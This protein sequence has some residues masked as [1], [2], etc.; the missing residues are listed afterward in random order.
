MAHGII[1]TQQLI[2]YLNEQLQPHRWKDYCPNGLQ[3]AGVPEIKHLVTAVSASQYVL[4]AA[5]KLRAQAILVHHGYFWK[6][7]DPCLIG[8]KRQRLATLLNH[9]INLIAYHL[10]LDGHPE[11]GNNVQL[12][13]LLHLRITGEFGYQHGPAIALIG[14]LPASMSGAE[15][16]KF[17]TVKLNRQPV[18]I[19]GNTDKIKRVAWTT[20]AGQNMIEQSMDH[21]IDAFITGEVSERTTHLAR[22]AGLHFFAA[23]HH[24]TEKYGVQ[25]LGNHLAEQFGIICEYIDINNPV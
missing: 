23:G 2:N 25:A 21:N 5:V 4:D 7:E 20:G 6:G 16:S 22:E 24:A 10:P 13:Q 11:W 1:Y 8:I 9:N 19:E 15:L 18:W 17:L 14:E 12:A 3:V